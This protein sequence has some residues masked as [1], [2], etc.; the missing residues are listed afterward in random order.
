M[1]KVY[2]LMTLKKSDKWVFEWG[3]MPQL[4]GTAS[5]TVGCQLA[6]VWQQKTIVVAGNYCATGSTV[7][8][9][10]KR[11]YLQFFAL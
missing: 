6:I 1:M 9:E 11:A 5:G 7:M 2:L 3:G 4:G 8:R 10:G